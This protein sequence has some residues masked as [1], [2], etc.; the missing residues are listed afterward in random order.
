MVKSIRLRHQESYFLLIHLSDIHRVEV[1]GSLGGGVEVREYH[2]SAGIAPRRDKSVPKRS[3]VDRLSV[4]SVTVH[5]FHFVF[6]GDQEM[7]GGG[8]P[9]DGG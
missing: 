7:P 4:G 5:D 6:A 1:V 8:E 9:L 3:R 2:D